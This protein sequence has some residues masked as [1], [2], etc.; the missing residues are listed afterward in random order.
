MK[1][2]GRKMLFGRMLT[3]ILFVVLVLTGSFGSGSATGVYAATGTGLS[4]K[5]LTLVEGKDK[6]TI[7]LNGT[8]AK[9][10]KSSD[11]S[12]VTVSSSGIVAGKKAG[13]ASVTVTGADGK[14][15]ICK[16]K[17]VKDS[18]KYTA[19]Y[20]AYVDILKSKEDTLNLLYRDW[21]ED[22]K[23]Q[24]KKNVAVVD[25]WGD[26]TP[27]LLFVEYGGEDSYIKEWD[28]L[29]I[30]TFQ[31]G[32][33]V[34]IYSQQ[35]I[36]SEESMYYYDY[37]IFRPKN[38][39]NVYVQLRGNVEESFWGTWSKISSSGKIKP[40]LIQQY[41]AA[42]L[43]GDINKFWQAFYDKN[44]KE[45]TEKEYKS[46]ENKIKAKDSKV[47]Y[48]SAY[49][50]DYPSDCMTYE[51]ALEK[52]T[53]Q[54]SKKKPFNDGLP[55]EIAKAYLNV[56]QDYSSEIYSYEYNNTFTGAEKSYALADVTND[57]IKEL[58]FF[59]VSYKSTDIEIWTYKN[60]GEVKKIFSDSASAISDDTR[61][62]NYY[63]LTKDGKL[64]KHS[65]EEIDYDFAGRVYYQESSS[66]TF[67]EL[68]NR[69]YINQS[70]NLWNHHKWYSIKNGVPY[71]GE[72]VNYAK[73]NLDISESTYYDYLKSLPEIDFEILSY[74]DG[75]VKTDEGRYKKMSMTKKEIMKKLNGK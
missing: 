59:S 6:V 34:K 20:S 35:L 45:I 63:Y 22:A 55:R 13:S 2:S 74:D 48:S 33:A 29:L 8:K 25:V 5:K 75:S 43:D 23:L 56:L 7:K 38:E 31:E 37:S 54:K 66:Y 27:E 15:Y 46:F 14:E 3:V 9:K 24:M 19:A 70:G 17:V 67:Y 21:R 61:E 1:K 12:V 42:Y 40:T 50:I 62:A 53:G 47:L 39:K 64:I 73:N 26:S 57:G 44:G 60:N 10:F 49:D 69:G 41:N 71:S 68:D 30:Y 58:I 36:T 18:G 4:A 65:T 32:K 28:N 16:V 11:T 72:E 51:E 52:L